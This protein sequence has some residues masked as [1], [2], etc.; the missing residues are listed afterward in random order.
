MRRCIQDMHLSDITIGYG[1]TETSPVS[2]QT[3]IGDTLEH[4]TATVGKVHPHVEVKIVDTEG[5]TV[6][7]AP[8]RAALRESSAPAAT[9]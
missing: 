8:C 3:L 4:Q 1:M 9:R 6:P 7:C 2:T 5:R